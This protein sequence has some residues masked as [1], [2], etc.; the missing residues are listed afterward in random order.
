MTEKDA[1]SVL[2]ERHGYP[3]SERYRRILE[4]LLTPQQARIAAEL[5]ASPEELAQKLT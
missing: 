2:M 4:Y 3:S 1:Y 5:P